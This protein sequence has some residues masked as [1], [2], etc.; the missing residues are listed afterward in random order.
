MDFLFKFQM[1]GCQFA[2][3]FSEKQVPPIK[4]VLSDVGPFFDPFFMQLN[5]KNQFIYRQLYQMP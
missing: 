3:L 2:N 4:Q 1:K 5:N